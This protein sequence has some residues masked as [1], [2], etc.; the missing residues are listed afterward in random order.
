MTWLYSQSDH[1]RAAKVGGWVLVAG[2][3]LAAL[4]LAWAVVA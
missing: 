4:A 3:L 1:D 2:A